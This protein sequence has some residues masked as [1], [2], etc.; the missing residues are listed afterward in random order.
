MLGG[1]RLQ[2]GERLYLQQ[3]CTVE[4]RRQGKSQELM[5]GGGHPGK[6]AA[7]LKT[8]VSLLGACALSQRHHSSHVTQ[9]SPPGQRPRESLTLTT[10]AAGREWGRCL[11]MD[12]HGSGQPGQFCHFP[13]PDPRPG[14]ASRLQCR[15]Q[16]V[17]TVP[18]C[19]GS[20]GPQKLKLV[21]DQCQVTPPW[22]RPPLLPAAWGHAAAF[23]Q[24]A[25]TLGST[26]R[27]VLR[28]MKDFTLL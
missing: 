3:S 2:D 27:G 11:G 21:L 10:Q 28:F 14:R 22:P 26:R 15:A 5:P 19:R 7:L 23:S 24:A 16:G 12:G 25:L 4:E 13:V 6:Q 17:R 9:A 8:P 1:A 20:P 18:R